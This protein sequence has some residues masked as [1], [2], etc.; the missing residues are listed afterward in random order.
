M[1]LLS[2][3][4]HLPLLNVF[5]K[6]YLAKEVNRIEY[7]HQKIRFYKCQKCLSFFSRRV[8]CI[9]ESIPRRSDDRRTSTVSVASE[10]LP[11]FVFH[12]TIKQLVFEMKIICFI[13]FV[14][15]LTITQ[16]NTGQS[17]I[18]IVIKWSSCYSIQTY[19]SD[20]NKYWCN[21]RLHYFIANFCSIASIKVG[22]WIKIIF[23]K[24]LL[25]VL[26]SFT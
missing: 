19:L 22:S 7:L 21:N 8:S 24:I 13:K 1:R 18:Q 3:R 17:S 12:L 26:K 15:I 14:Q 2:F 23:C 6:T 10:W 20:K 16:W 5:Q 11:L 25:V 9:Y 4:N